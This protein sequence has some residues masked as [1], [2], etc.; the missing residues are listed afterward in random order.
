[1]AHI[2]VKKKCDKPQSNS[3]QRKADNFVWS[4]APT[5]FF[6]KNFYLEWSVRGVCYFVIPSPIITAV[7]SKCVTENRQET[8]KKKQEQKVKQYCVSANKR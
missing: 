4:K 6:Q 8:K 3:N 7:H 2:P 1:M 5:I